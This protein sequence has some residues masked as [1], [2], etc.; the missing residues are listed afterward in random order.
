M[1][2]ARHANVKTVLLGALILAFGLG[3]AHAQAT[4]DAAQAAESWVGL[5]D[6]ARYAENWQAAASFFKNA[7]P[8]QKWVE[9]AQT[10]RRPL[11]PVK[12]R[13]AKS[14]AETKTLPGAPDGEYI[15]FQFN[16]AFEKKAAAVETI[17]VL[18]EPD[19]QWR[20]VGYFVR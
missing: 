11:G 8:Q 19:G 17:T 3:P 18:R 2:K 15:V 9:A 7:L 16:A 13:A 20:V 1:G 6:G 12:S 5:V 14:R 10:A 4:N